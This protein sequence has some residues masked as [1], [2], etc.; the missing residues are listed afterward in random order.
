MV[1]GSRDP[2]IRT[3]NGANHNNGGD[4]DGVEEEMRNPGRNGN[5]HPFPL[6][7]IASSPFSSFTWRS[8]R[9]SD[10]ATN[11][12]RTD[13][14]VL[15]VLGSGGFGK[16]YKVQ[17]KLDSKC[18]ALKVVPMPESVDLEHPTTFSDSNP[19]RKDRNNEPLQLRRVLREVE[20]LSGIPSNDH[21]VRYY[22]AWVEKTDD[23]NDLLSHN[24]EDSCYSD[25]CR[26]YQQSTTD[27]DESS[28]SY[29]SSGY[30]STEK[31]NDEETRKYNRTRRSGPV[32]HLCKLS[33]DDWEVGFEYWGLIDSV[34]QPLDLCVDCYKQSLPNNIDTSKMN[35]RK[36][37]P[38]RRRLYILMEYCDSTLEKTMK[39]LQQGRMGNR[40]NDHL[41]EQT[42]KATSDGFQS[43]N[44]NDD[45][46]DRCWSY[47]RQTVKGVAHLHA[48]GI[49]HR[50]IKP[51][52]VFLANEGLAEGTVKI[53]DL[54]LA[55]IDATRTTPVSNGSHQ[56]F[57]SESEE[58]GEEKNTETDPNNKASTGVKQSSGV[59]TF[60]YR[61]PEIDTGRY[62]E[63]CDVYSLGILLVEI[64]SN[65]ETAM[66]RAKVLGDLKRTRATPKKTP[67][68]AAGGDGEGLAFHVHLAHRMTALDPNDRPTCAEILDELDN[69]SVFRSTKGSNPSRSSSS[70][71][72]S[73]SPAN[74]EYEE[75][76]VLMEKDREIARL[77]NLLAAH[78]ISY[79]EDDAR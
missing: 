55:T 53:G 19:S 56:D 31:D 74:D 5:G 50:D 76:P 8:R 69:L 60:L 18:Y 9:M 40:K 26:D 11:R 38:Y 66:E 15:D 28:V 44:N 75:N 73:P 62:N 43:N 45:F 12:H 41:L 4:R 14:V 63:K 29:S 21:I 70:L 39:I 52:N 36:V 47:F 48:S 7:S 51:N 10:E 20:I 65:F 37:R 32:C 2:A 17:N 61:A 6:L 72:L 46:A 30:R 27:Y 58:E 71:S 1:E 49:I 23:E 16:V 3:S 25:S 34:L 22:A 68:A 42:D 79:E 33:Y 57:E 67:V 78:G 24:Q 64:F 77:R 35:I 59:G 54:G 13:F